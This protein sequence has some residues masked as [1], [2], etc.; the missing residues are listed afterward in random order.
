MSLVRTADFYG[1]DRRSMLHW[2]A[3]KKRSMLRYDE[4]FAAL[5]TNADR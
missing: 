2:E 4:A 5:E 3:A 1:T